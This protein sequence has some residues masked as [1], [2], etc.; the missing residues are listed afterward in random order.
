MDNP[1]NLPSPTTINSLSIY[2]GK[3]CTVCSS[4]DIVVVVEELCTQ[5]ALIQS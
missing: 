2:S 5:K 1:N 3:E 4:G